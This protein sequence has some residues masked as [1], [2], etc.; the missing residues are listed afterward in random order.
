[1]CR[2]TFCSSASVQCFIQKYA[3][4]VPLYS[5]VHVRSTTVF[6][7]HIHPILSTTVCSAEKPTC[8]LLSNLS[9]YPTVHHATLIDPYRAHAQ[10]V[11]AGTRKSANQEPR[12]FLI[13]GILARYVQVGACLSYC[14]QWHAVQL[15]PRLVD[16]ATVVTS[17]RQSLC[18]RSNCGYSFSARTWQSL[19]SRSLYTHNNAPLGGRRH[20]SLRN[21]TNSSKCCR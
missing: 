1:M 13:W 21:V 14:S 12:L 20:L 6:K 16:S 8:G 9:I 5:N 11:L 19:R 15:V 4:G 3:V 18:I 7:G 10:P 17:R 2:Q